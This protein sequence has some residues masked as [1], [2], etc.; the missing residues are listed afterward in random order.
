MRN[1]LSL[2]IKMYLHDLDPF[3]HHGAVNRINNCSHFVPESPNQRPLGHH[4]HDN[5]SVMNFDLLNPHHHHASSLPH[6]SHINIMPSS[7]PITI[8]IPRHNQPQQPSAPDILCQTND[9]SSICSS[10]MMSSSSQQSLLSC[11]VEGEDDD[12]FNKPLEEPRA[13]SVTTS[14]SGSIANLENTTEKHSSGLEPP[15]SVPDEDSL[16]EKMNS[17]TGDIVVKLKSAPEMKEQKP[18][19]EPTCPEKKSPD[20]EPG[21]FSPEKAEQTAGSIW[22][23]LHAWDCHSVCYI[24]SCEIM[25]VSQ[26]RCSMLS[27]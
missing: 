2:R 13:A 17:N 15:T 12:V 24:E 22:L 10:S 21:L 7:Q 19:V 8:S 23:L 20:A 26:R 3:Q 11:L 1:P 27:T 25:K 4:Y 9:E 14:S 18:D 16:S 5:F 6:S